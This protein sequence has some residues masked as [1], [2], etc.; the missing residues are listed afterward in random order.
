MHVCLKEISQPTYVSS[1]CD[2]SE[3]KCYN[4]LTISTELYILSLYR[5]ICI[6]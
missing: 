4:V 3:Y 2:K 6:N 1:N 5:Q